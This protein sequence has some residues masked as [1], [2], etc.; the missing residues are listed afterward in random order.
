MNRTLRMAIALILIVGVLYLADW[1]MVVAELGKL[2]FDQIFILLT[3]SAILVYLSSLKWGYFLQKLDNEKPVLELFQY[4]LGGYAI[5]LIFPAFIGGDV[6]RGF[7][8]NNG[9]QES[10]RSLASV[11]MERFTGVLAMLILTSVVVAIS[12][13]A[14]LAV[15]LVVWGLTLGVIT[16]AYVVTSKRILTWLERFTL[17]S[18][19]LPFT[20][21]LQLAL[22]FAGSDL[23]LWGKSMAV[24][25]LYHSFTIVNVYA[26]ALC[27]GWTAV[28]LSGLFVVVPLIL[29]I[30]SLPL[31]PSGLGIQ[32]GAYF[33]FLQQLGA[34]SPQAAAIMVILRAKTY[35]LAAV[36]AIIFMLHKKNTFRAVTL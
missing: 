20:K 34:T 13:R 10:H 22:S 8:V 9:K 35:V 32:D 28:P 16:A 26:C 19:V 2:T 7:M 17:L 33:Y 21:K 14:I 24:S 25:F 31:T 23:K 27:V 1:R 5:N 3:I 30:G 6:T 29:V 11:A 36:G 15:K 12:S 4:Y 18:K